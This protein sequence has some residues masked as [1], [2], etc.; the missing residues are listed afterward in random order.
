MTLLVRLAVRNLWRNRRRTVITFSALS[1]G[2]ALLVVFHSISTGFSNIGF[3]NVRDF[4]TGELQVHAVGYFEERERLPLEPVLPGA[5]ALAAVADAP[6]V[7][8]VTPRLVTGARLHAGWEEFPVTAIAVDPETD[9]SVFRLQE[10]V[11]GRMPRAG[12]AE[13]II[14]STLAEWLDIELGDF[15]LLITRTR[16]EA[17]EA[18]DL[19]V[20]GIARTPHPS[21]NQGHV[22][23][24]LDVADV[25]LGLE[26]H[27]TELTIRADGGHTVEDVVAAARQ[28]LAAQGVEA[29]VFRWEEAAEDLLGLMQADTVGN[30]MMTGVIMLIALV[31]VTNTI[32]LGVLERK[33]E[34]GIMKALGFR[35]KHIIGLFLA[36]ASGIGVLAALTGSAVGALINLYLVTKGFNMDAWFG[37]T[38]FGIPV[39]GTVYGVWNVQVFIWGAVAGIVTCW[40][41]A[42]WPARYAAHLPA[43]EA[44]RG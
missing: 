39:V 42:Y 40:I 15:V 16:R 36:E 28:A 2:I 29:E 24:P 12:A 34:I 22:Y 41:A 14:G 10:H 20:V 23:F 21:L 35:E 7:K 8:A 44:V 25:V 30:L 3:Q 17:L 18:L 26:G 31:G 19:E 1:F 11:Y 37:D 13:A 27:V 32:L 6:G 38:D 33:P 9:G 43:A 5:P 4:Q